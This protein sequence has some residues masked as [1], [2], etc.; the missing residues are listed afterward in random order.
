MMESLFFEQLSD[1]VVLQSGPYAVSET[2]IIEFGQRFDPRS[3]HIDPVAAKQSVFGGLVAPGSLTF[4]IR[5]ALMNQL[6]PPI[7]YLAG[8]GLEQ[9]DLPVPVR[10]GDQLFLRVQCLQK[11]ISR[12]R[13]DAGIVRLANTLV[14]QK[15]EV[16]LS[17][18]AKVLVARQTS[19]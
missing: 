17:M 12:S 9:M 13:P 18:V 6:N 1:T 5:S 19:V 16:V 15:D 11:R 8:L 3:F 10:P 14:N 7:A 2:E 4:A